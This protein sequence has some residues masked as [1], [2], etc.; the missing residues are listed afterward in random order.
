[1]EWQVYGVSNIIWDFISMKH[2]AVLSTMYYPDMG[3]PSAVVDKYVQLLRENNKVTIITKTYKNQNSFDSRDDVRYITGVRHHLILWCETNIQSKKLSLLSKLILKAIDAYK[4]VATQF[5][6][7]T[8]NSWENVGYYE[9]L[10]K[11]HKDDKIDCIISVSNTAFCQ[12]AAQKFK[13]KYPTTKWVTFITDPFAENYIYY[14]FKMF[15]TWWKQRNLASEKSFYMD[16][17]HNFL[18]VEMFKFAKDTL[19]IPL[20]KISCLHF[21]LDN[22][23]VDLQNNY[24]PYSSEVRLIYAGAVYHDIRNPEY[25]L[26]LISS[27]PELKLDMFINTGECEDVLALYAKNNITRQGYAPKDKYDQM[28]CCEYDILV[29]IGNISTLQ[30]P[31]KTVDLLSTGKPI[32]NFYFVK[33]SQYEMIERYPLGLNIQDGEVNV[34]DKVRKFC[35]SMKGKRMPFEE[36]EKLYPENNIKRQIDLLENV[37]EK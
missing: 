3:A 35:L 8:A 9:Q 11:L 25:M 34:L 13:K 26:R 5:M 36:V 37:I 17:D 29:N 16:A 21:A 12:F 27:L 7:P 22:R 2:I 24:F 23:Y 33:D 19:Q 18:T 30:A 15:K 10:E 6:N 28:I 32:L 4:L 14:R 20:N 1:M 31:S